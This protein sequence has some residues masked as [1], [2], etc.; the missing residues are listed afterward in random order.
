MTALK[1]RDIETFLAKPSLNQG[2]I[3]VYGPDGGLV[4]ENAGR[5]LKAFAGDPPDP[6]SLVTLHMSEIDADAQRLGIEARTPSLFGSGKVIRVRAATNK[7]TATLTELLDEKADALF[8]VEGGDLKPSDSLRKLAEQRRDARALPCY[9][10]TGQ[11][12]DKLIRESFA[13]ANITTEPDLVPF[14]RDMLGNDRQVTRG[15]IEKLVLYAGEGGSLTRDDVTALCGDNAALALDAVVDAIASGHARNFDTALTR[16]AAAGT[17][18]QR[19]LAVALNHFAR[20]RAM[21]SQI[22]E[23]TPPN[24]V[25]DRATPR[26]HFSRKSAM[27]QQLRIWNDDGLASACARL[28]LAVAQSRKSS[29]LAQATARQ[30]MLAVCMAAARR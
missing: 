14:L 23:G 25:I 24:Q 1:G 6:E 12:L 2:F 4:S 27:E 7:L 11:S 5:L 17:D 20:L 18:T 15:E 19:I 30:A 22:D 9:A 3:L 28:S 21:R 8:I 26:I 13:A 29:A 10:D 16:A